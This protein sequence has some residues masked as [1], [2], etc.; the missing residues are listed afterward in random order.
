[1]TETI[2][3][4]TQA[5]LRVC[6]PQQITLFAEKRTMATGKLKAFSPV[7]YTHL[8]VY[9]RQVQYRCGCCTLQWACP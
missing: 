1:M 4:A 9:K 6:Q 3:R 2:Q 8:D 7:S 5:I